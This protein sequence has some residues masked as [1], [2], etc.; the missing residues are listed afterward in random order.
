[1]LLLTTSQR[2]V[3]PQGS[4]FI[5]P[6]SL[7]QS[8]PVSTWLP[9]RGYFQL[10]RQQNPKPH[11]LFAPIKSCIHLHS[12]CTPMPWA[13]WSRDGRW[14]PTR[15]GLYWARMIH[16]CLWCSTR[17]KTLDHANRW[18]YSGLSM[19]HGQWW[20]E[21]CLCWADQERWDVQFLRHVLGWG[22]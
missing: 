4:W 3:T 6:M 12:G 14:A 9:P 1:M 22:K 19:Y 16:N 21:W 15:D 17:L 11:V 10:A 2:K 8:L 7:S 18:R 20:E 13:R 5:S